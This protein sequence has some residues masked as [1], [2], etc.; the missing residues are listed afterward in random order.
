MTQ[1]EAYPEVVVPP[2]RFE[3]GVWELKDYSIDFSD[4]LPTGDTIVSS[5]WVADTGL[6]I[7]E[8]AFTPTSTTVWIGPG[9][10]PSY[11][12][13]VINSIQTAQGRTESRRM[14]V[15]VKER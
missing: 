5:M 11:A 1:P 14:W 9:G 12:Y 8:F 2:A 7:S 15:K 4:W 10:L 3:Q 13:K 6:L